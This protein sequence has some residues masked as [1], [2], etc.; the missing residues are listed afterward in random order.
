MFPYQITDKGVTVFIDNKPRMFAV[1]HGQYDDVVE[2]IHSGSEQAVRDATDVRAS[3]FQKSLGRVRIEGNTIFV[4]DEEQKGSLVDRILA[5]VA[6]GS[7]AVDGYI[8]FLDRVYDIES[9]GVRESVFDFI[10]ACNLPVT[11][12]G[13]FLGYKYVRHDYTDGRTGKI[14]NSVGQRVKMARRDCD[15][16]R[17]QT[18]S[19]GLHV[20]S[21]EY[22]GGANATYGSPIMVVKVAPEDVVAVPFEYAMAKMRTC[23]YDV[24]GELDRFND[25]QRIPDWYTEEYTES[26]DSDSDSDEPEVDE[27]ESLT[28]DQILVFDPQ[29]VIDSLDAIG[30]D[31][32][33]IQVYLHTLDDELVEEL[34]DWSVK[35]DPLTGDVHVSIWLYDEVLG[36]SDH[37]VK[38]EVATDEPEVPESLLPATSGRGKLTPDQ[39]RA[40]YARKQDWA[41]GNVTL[42][43]L[44]AEYGVHREQIAR[45]FRGETWSH[46]TGQ[47]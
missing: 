38:A 29:T 43:A 7:K 46:I 33:A 8:R 16:N 22:L 11:E 36:V 39:V 10:E 15:D 37:V 20:C 32:D 12:D 3:I 42:T 18:C 44:G 17:N 21:L 28:D 14:D 9:M 5:M 45:I 35:A 23:G 1:S 27:P 24:V 34:H 30:A 47:T 41:D 6:M 40:I 25:G 13:C 19:S 2:A 26:D 4:N 31:E